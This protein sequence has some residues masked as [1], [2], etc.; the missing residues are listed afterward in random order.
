MVNCAPA[1][2]DAVSAA[3]FSTIICVFTISCSLEKVTTYLPVVSSK[4]TLSPVITALPFLLD[5][6]NS[7]SLFVSS[8]Y[9]VGAVTSW[10]KYVPVCVRS[11][12]YSPS[13]NS[14][15]VPYSDLFQRDSPTYTLKVKFPVSVIVAPVSASIFLMITLSSRLSVVRSSFM[16][17]LLPSSVLPSLSNTLPSAVTVNVTSSAMS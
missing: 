7:T 13:V 8:L 17:T 15:T 4:E 11:N 12:S 1:I 3:Y 14:S 9:P 16:T 10:R 2:T 6:L 5:T